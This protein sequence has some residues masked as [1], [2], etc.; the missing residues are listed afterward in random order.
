MAKVDINFQRKVGEV[1][2]NFKRQKTVVKKSEN[3]CDGCCYFIR[4]GFPRLCEDRI[5][6][7]GLCSKEM[8]KDKTNV[9]FIAK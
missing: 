2:T 9:K 1:F 7:T 8:R 6:E 4:E 5:S 3:G